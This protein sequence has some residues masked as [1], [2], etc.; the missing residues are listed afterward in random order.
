MTRQEQR[1]ADS[2]RRRRT[3]ASANVLRAS[4]TVYRRGEDVID[5]LLARCAMTGEAGED[6]RIDDDAALLRLVTEVG[7]M[8][9]AAVALVL[10]VSKERVRQIE[11]QAVSKIV[12]TK[13][14]SARAEAHRAKLYRRLEELLRKSTAGQAEAEDYREMEDVMLAIDAMEGGLLELFTERANRRPT[15]WESVEAE[16]TGERW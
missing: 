11:A 1:R 6:V 15:L 3:L 9:L 12:P 7:P 5:M 14:S 8:T 16:G 4:H 10:Q 13:V 2:E